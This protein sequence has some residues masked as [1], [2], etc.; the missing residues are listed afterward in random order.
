MFA[1]TRKK[2]L[3]ANKLSK[4]SCTNNYILT[5]CNVIAQPL[6]CN[7]MYKES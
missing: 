7:D 6:Q 3:Y 5:K 2:F 1:R 4:L